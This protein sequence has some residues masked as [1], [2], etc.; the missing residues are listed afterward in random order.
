ML[1]G[2]IK[3]KNNCKSDKVRIKIEKTSHLLQWLWEMGFQMKELFRFSL[4]HLFCKGNGYM[5][6]LSF[7]TLNGVQEGFTCRFKGK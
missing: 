7:K 5:C 2:V 1:S 4:F 3:A 6:P